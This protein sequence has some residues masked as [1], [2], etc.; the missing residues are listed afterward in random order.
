M[1]RLLLL[2]VRGLLL[3][4]PTW[5]LQAWAEG[6]GQLGQTWLAVWVSAGQVGQEGLLGE[7]WEQQE[8]LS[9]EAWEQQ[10]G[11]SGEAWEQQEGLSG[12]GWEQQEGLSGEVEV[13][14]VL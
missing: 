14:E 7:A 13:Q 11:L 8:G 6:E 12:E 2:I 5:P 4:I 9:G 10:E 3:E 1:W